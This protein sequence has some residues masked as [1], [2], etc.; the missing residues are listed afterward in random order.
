MSMDKARNEFVMAALCKPADASLVELHQLLL[1]MLDI[2]EQLP[3]E[4]PILAALA[5]FEEHSEWKRLQQ[6][7]RG[8][9]EQGGGNG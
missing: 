9:H 4:E 1:D 6:E 2:H 8:E 7:R 5:A 3:S